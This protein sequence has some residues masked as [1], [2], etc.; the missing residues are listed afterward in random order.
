MAQWYR[1][2]LARQEALV[3]SLTQETPQAA[4][5]L[6]PHPAATE[7]LAPKSLCS[8]TRSHRNEKPTHLNEEQPSLAAAREKSAQQRRPSTAKKKRQNLNGVGGK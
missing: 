1:V 4:G 5:Q 8:A 2:R 7:A 6:S 3:Q